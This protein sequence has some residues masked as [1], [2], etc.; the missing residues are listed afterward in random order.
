[1]IRFGMAARQKYP[2]N[3]AAGLASA[4]TKRFSEQKRKTRPLTD[5]E[6]RA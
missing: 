3:V 6:G 1:M 4:R 2:A 5:A